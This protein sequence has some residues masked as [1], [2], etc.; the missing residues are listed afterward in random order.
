MR[1]A[2]LHAIFLDLHKACDALDRSRYLDILEG[3]GV[4][5]RALRLLSRYWERLQMVAQA[6][7]YYV[8]PF[9]GEIGVTQR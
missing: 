1:V 6:G 8:G 5:P 7:G 4:V 9:R 3:Y 2:V